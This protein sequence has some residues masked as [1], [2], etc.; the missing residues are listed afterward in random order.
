[1]PWPAF[2]SERVPGAGD[3]AEPLRVPPEG[4]TLPHSSIPPYNLK[5][6]SPG[7]VKEERLEHGRT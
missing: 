2:L 3:W 6:T 1:M 7:A 5:S 4:W